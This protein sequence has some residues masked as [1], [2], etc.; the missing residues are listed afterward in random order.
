MSGF[1]L[2]AKLNAE[3]SRRWRPIVFMYSRSDGMSF[4]KAFGV[5]AID[6]LV[7]PF[8]REQLPDSVRNKPANIMLRNNG[9]VALVD[10]GIAKELDA[11]NTFT[12]HGDAGYL[13]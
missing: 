9:T 2:A 1:D 7:K 11:A 12:W 13:A 5:G 4:R 6:Y 8:T 3:E 10:F